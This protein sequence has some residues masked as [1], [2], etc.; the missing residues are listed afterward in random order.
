[1]AEQITKGELILEIQDK[2]D[3]YED[4]LE[5]TFSSEVSD[6][7]N[8]VAISNLYIALATLFANK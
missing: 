2:I 8:R 1:M 6:S 5:S 4:V 7:T 3:K